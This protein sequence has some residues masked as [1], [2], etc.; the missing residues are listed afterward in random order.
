MYDLVRKSSLYYKEI[1]KDAGYRENLVDPILLVSDLSLFNKAK[2]NCDADYL[3]LYS[4][5]RLMK[6]LY[7]SGDERY[8]AFGNYLREA[9]NIGF[10]INDISL[11][12]KSDI[13]RLNDQVELMRMFMSFKYCPDDIALTL[14]NEMQ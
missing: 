14:A 4:L 1:M 8:H 6:E 12:Q 9:E 11:Q 3:N 7:N 13:M 10:I 5:I 2:K